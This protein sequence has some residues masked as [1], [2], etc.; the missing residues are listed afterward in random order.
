V[1]SAG[2][3]TKNISAGEN[4]LPE[5]HSVGVCVGGGG[6]DGQLMNACQLESIPVEGE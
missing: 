3:R 1:N 5:S 2:L 4:Y 6:R